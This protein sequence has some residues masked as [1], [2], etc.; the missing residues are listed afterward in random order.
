MRATAWAAVLTSAATMLGLGGAAW[1]TPTVTVLNNS[2]YRYTSMA[3]FAPT[4]QTVTGVYGDVPPLP[5]I[6][7]V[8]G[9]WQLTFAPR[10]DF[11]AQAVNTFGGQDQTFDGGLMF[12]ITF[13]APV[14]ITA[15][16]S[17]SGFY[18]TTGNG[19]WNVSGLMEIWD[20]ADTEQR[21]RAFPAPSFA[22]NAWNLTD[23]VA[24]FNGSY[25][26]YYVSLDNILRATS[27][28]L[29]TAGSALVAKK[30]FSITFITDGGGGG[31]PEPAS[32]SVLAVG[33]LALMA[34]RRRA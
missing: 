24:G 17:E 28:G 20:A 32:L 34:R 31:V 29:D 19:T 10:A 1:A 16:L 11:T 25:T 33:S 27:V 9:G 14:R 8:T 4:S 3:A 22:D 2:G 7:P 23:T 13:D 6:T 15:N 21:Q 26:T 5:D 30:K 18:Q 12:R